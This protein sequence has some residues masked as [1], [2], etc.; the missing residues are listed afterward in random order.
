VLAYYFTKISRVVLFWIAFVLTRPFG[1]T[2]GDLLTKPKDHG[3][4]AYGTKGASLI[5]FVLLVVLVII[6]TVKL[7]KEKTHRKE[8]AFNS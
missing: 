8:L 7:S 4:L 1:A 2:F 5:L 3:G 6:E